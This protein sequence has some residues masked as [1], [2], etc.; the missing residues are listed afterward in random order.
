MNKQTVD[1][2]VTDYL[3]KLYG[4]SVRKSFSYDEAEELCSEILF[5]VYQS[6][7]SADDIVNLEGYIWRI[8]ENTYARFISSKKKHQGISINGMEIPHYDETD[9]DDLESVR[10]L[11]REIAFLSEVR[12]KIVFLFYYKKLSIVSISSELSLPEGTVKWHLNKARKEL[13]EGYSMER[14]IG[15]L[16]LS[17]IE[18]ISFGHG[19]T[20][21]ASGGPEHYLGDKVRL[22]IV[23]SVYHSPK[24]KQEIAQELGLTPVYIEDMVNYLEDNG[25]IVKTKNDKYTTYVKFSPEQYS[26][27]RQENLIRT[28]LQVARDLVREYVPLV[29]EAIR[30]TENIY[31]PTGNRELF[32]A[33]VILYSILSKCRLEY[34]E[35]LP[36]YIIKT[37]DGGRYYAFVVIDSQCSD[38]EYETEF[39]DL[40][41]YWACGSMNRYSEKYPNLFSWS[42]DSR[43]SSREGG[44]K[45]NLTEDYEYLYEFIKGDINDTPANSEKIKRL[46]ERSFIADDN[47]VNVMI[48]KGDKKDLF[49]KIP[50]LDQAVK[51]KYAKTALENAMQTAKNYP[52]QM[53]DL[54]VNFELGDFI[55][56]RVALM[57]MDILYSD[58]TFE[59][60]TERERITSNLIMFSDVLPQA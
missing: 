45:N 12:R 49:D 59:H 33:A 38:P 6:L 3:Q 4:F 21:G 28:Q 11:R 19:G 41:S 1:Q 56:S 22:N 13:K 14:K 25:Y 53:Q 23:Y 37:T 47:S 7:L 48:F 57:V 50:P 60:L 55:G 30:K 29:R 34:E 18:A 52:P 27:E 24:T 54:I 31:I 40:P 46:R 44:W 39:K 36:K 20:P 15:K 58:G 10:I 42:V 35:E 5:E 26:L 8:S 51:D 2:I 16:G 9:L 17:P 43:L 32:E